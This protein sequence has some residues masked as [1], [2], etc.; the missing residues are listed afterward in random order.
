MQSRTLLDDMLMKKQEKGKY[1][2]QK[3][4]NISLTVM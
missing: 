4:V 3:K 1:L 2:K